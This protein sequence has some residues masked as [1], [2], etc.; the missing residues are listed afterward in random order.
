[1][2]S[3]LQQGEDINEKDHFGQTALTLSSFFG[4]LEK[5]RFL[6][7]NGA[8]VDLQQNVDGQT[9]LHCAATSGKVEAAK[10]LLRA[11]ASTDIRNIDNR[12][13][14]DLANDRKHSEV[15][16]IL[17]DPQ[18][19]R[20]APT[21]AVVSHTEVRKCGCCLS[22]GTRFFTAL[23]WKGGQVENGQKGVCLK[24]SNITQGFVSLS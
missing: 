21:Q 4:Y 5:V 1:M 2:R 20:R 10:E 6:L 16:S 9:A 13:A 22:G 14:L 24:N 3:L 8:E 19:W 23:K 15:A 7:E 12:T 17:R 11:G 18:R